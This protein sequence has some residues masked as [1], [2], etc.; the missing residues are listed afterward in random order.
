MLSDGRGYEAVLPLDDALVPEILL[1]FELDGE[2]L[3]AEHGGPLRAVVPTAYAWKS[4]KWLRRIEL[5][6]EPRPGFWDR[7][8][9]HPAADPWAEERMA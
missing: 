8:G 1:A 6:T 4:V 9:Y 5:C 3:A 7:R 2:P